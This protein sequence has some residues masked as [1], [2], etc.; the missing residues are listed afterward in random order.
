MLITCLYSYKY[1]FTFTCV[2]RRLVGTKQL[3]TLA[4]N[5]VPL[6]V[7]NGKHCSFKS[8]LVWQGYNGKKITAKSIAWIYRF[9][10]SQ[11]SWSAHFLL[12][13]VPLLACSCC[14][15][16]KFNRLFTTFLEGVDFRKIKKKRI[17]LNF[18]F[19]G[20]QSKLMILMLDS[21]TEELFAKFCELCGFSNYNTMFI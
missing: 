21:K 4:A 12:I 14:H 10:H 19:R 16:R 7:R 6:T 15:W 2:S 11:A 5:H 18:M 1:G 8:H 20:S 17:N 3:I 13:S 9:F